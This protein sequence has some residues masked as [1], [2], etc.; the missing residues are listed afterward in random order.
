MIVKSYFKMKEININ[1]Y[2][3]SYISDLKRIM[4]NKSDNQI[5]IMIIRKE[6]KRKRENE[7]INQKFS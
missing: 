5:Y 6:K 1:W 2:I 3:I 7:Y 4:H